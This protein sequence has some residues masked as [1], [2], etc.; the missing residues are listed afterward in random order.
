M[1]LNSLLQNSPVAAVLAPL[2]AL[3]A[4]A[5]A[6]LLGACT[7]RLRSPRGRRG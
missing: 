2:V 3:A 6:Q 7:R 1:I 4:Y 5:V